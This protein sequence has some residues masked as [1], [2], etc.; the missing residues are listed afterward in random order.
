MH[1][2]TQVTKELALIL[3]LLA[4]EFAGVFLGSIHM[5]VKLDGCNNVKIL[6]YEQKCDPHRQLKATN[7]GELGGIAPGKI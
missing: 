6:H 1:V 5:A 4:G 2:A 3:Q 7:F